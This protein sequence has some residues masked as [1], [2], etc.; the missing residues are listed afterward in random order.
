MVLPLYRQCIAAVYIQSVPSFLTCYG[1]SNMNACIPSM[2]FHSRFSWTAL[3]FSYIHSYTKLLHPHMF[4]CM[5]DAGQGSLS[6]FQHV[7]SL[8]MHLNMSLRFPGSP[9]SL[10]DGTV[11]QKTEL[12]ALIPHTTKVE[13]RNQY[14]FTCL[15]CS[16]KDCYFRYVF[17]P[18][19]APSYDTTFSTHVIYGDY[20]PVSMKYRVMS[21][22]YVVE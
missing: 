18:K 14:R 8:A 17:V 10:P 16:F 4:T 7:N 20:Y 11:A 13:T 6:V 9:Q 1:R 15:A 5:F 3:L 22:V 12:K 19:Y 21:H 2:T